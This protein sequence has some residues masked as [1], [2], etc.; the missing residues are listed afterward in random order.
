MRF[1]R[2][3]D[4]KT[5]FGKMR[6]DAVNETLRTETAGSVSGQNQTRLLSCINKISKEMITRRV[7]KAIPLK[8]SKNLILGKHGRMK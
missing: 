1:L 6:F 7:Y 2:K 5:F 8:K 4:N 3:T